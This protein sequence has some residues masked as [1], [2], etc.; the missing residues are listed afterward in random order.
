M[1]S[2]GKDTVVVLFHSITTQIDV[3]TR[4]R[5]VSFIKCSMTV[6]ARDVASMIAT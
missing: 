2:T 5:V 1:Q 6:N 3:S 4:P